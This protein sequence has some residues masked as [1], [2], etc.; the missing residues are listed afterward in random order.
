M[1]L[2]IIGGLS[3]LLGFYTRFGALALLLFLVPVTLIM[4]NFWAIEDAAAAQEQM[5]NFMKNVSITGAVLFILAVGPGPIS[6]DNARQPKPP[7][8][9]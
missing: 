1:A 9:A 3:V 4:H 7:V 6:I 5:I 8:V 2:E